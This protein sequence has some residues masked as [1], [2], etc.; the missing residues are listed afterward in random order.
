MHWYYTSCFYTSLAIATRTFYFLKHPYIKACMNKHAIRYTNMYAVLYNVC[1][2][3]R[4]SLAMPLALHINQQFRQ[5]LMLKVA[6]ADF[7]VA[8]FWGLSVA[9]ECLGCLQTASY[10]L[11]KQ[12]SGCN[13]HNWL[14]SWAMDLSALYDTYMEVKMA[15][16]DAIWLFIVKM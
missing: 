14:M 12:T 15:P 9:H 8:C 5:L 10:P 7:A 1:P 11:G 4:V 3:I 13:L 6:Q 2:T 16:M